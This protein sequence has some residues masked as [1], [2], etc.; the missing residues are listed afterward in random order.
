VSYS[1]TVVKSMSK[2]NVGTEAALLGATA[3]SAKARI[4]GCA[5]CVSD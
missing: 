1:E 5:I 2:S 4:A 3:D